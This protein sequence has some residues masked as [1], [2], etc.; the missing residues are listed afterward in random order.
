MA[1]TKASLTSLAA[2]ISETTAA[3]TAILE[4]NNVPAPSFAEDGLV[5]YP[6]IP[7]AIGLRL[8]LIDAVSDLYLMAMGPSDMGFV[9]PLIVS[10]CIKIALFRLNLLQ[11]T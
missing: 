9:Q 5:E 3:L 11:L 6:R 8:Q 4:K 10:L 2:T 1:D 7:E